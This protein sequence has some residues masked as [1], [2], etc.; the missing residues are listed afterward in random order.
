MLRHSADVFRACQEGKRDVSTPRTSLMR[1][2]AEAGLVPDPQM[3]IR[4][5]RRR[6][7]GGKT[8]GAHALLLG[9]A[10]LGDKLVAADRSAA[11]RPTNVV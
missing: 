8:A 9:G 7:D 2:C 3:V 4:S 6:R 5:P 11:P 10:G 1:Q